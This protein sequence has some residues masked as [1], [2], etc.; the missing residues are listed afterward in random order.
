[1]SLNFVFV[2]FFI[3]FVAIAIFRAILL[4]MRLTQTL[5][6]VGVSPEAQHHVEPKVSSGPADSVEVRPSVASPAPSSIRPASPE[7]DGAH[8]CLILMFLKS[9]H[10]LDRPID[11]SGNHVMHTIYIL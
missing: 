7:E 6:N 9:N 1:M 2:V 4:F 10:F 3:I 8:N 5:H 11:D